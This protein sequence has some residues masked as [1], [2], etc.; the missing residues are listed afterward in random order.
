MGGPRRGSAHTPGP[1]RGRHECYA[2]RMGV[3]LLTMKALIPFVTLALAMAS[4]AGRSAFANERAS[5]YES[6]KDPR[7]LNAIH[8]V[9]SD[10]ENRLGG[11]LQDVQIYSPA[12]ESPAAASPIPDRQHR[13]VFNLNTQCGHEGCRL[14]S[15]R[16][17]QTRHSRA[18]HSSPR[19]TQRESSPPA[20][21]LGVWSSTCGNG[22][23]GGQ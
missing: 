7:C 20:P 10:I 14:L 19:N 23:L 3:L 22:E 17:T 9:H 13:I 6:I 15:R 2:I 21:M 16:T 5:A 1:W 18:A 12:S 8:Q 11:D 4:L